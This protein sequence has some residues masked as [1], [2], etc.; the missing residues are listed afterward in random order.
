MEKEIENVHQKILAIARELFVAQGYDRISMREIA[1]ACGLSKP[2]LY[3]YF[4]DK[5]ALFLA[6]L[7][8]QLTELEKTLLNIESQPGSARGKIR[9]FLRSIFS[10]PTHQSA[11]I[12]LAS[13]DMEKVEASAR[14]AFNQRYQDKFLNLLAEILTEGM[15][16][17][18]LRSLDTH[19]S[20][21]ALLGLMYPYLNRHFSTDSEVERVIDFIDSVLFDGLAA[22]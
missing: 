7:D 3:Y 16:S 5:Q 11:I 14:A 2:G 15:K 18:E 13:Q 10:Q 21:W 4:T 17:G 6:I 20:V 19:L 1:E 12:R 22:K 9:T 8:D